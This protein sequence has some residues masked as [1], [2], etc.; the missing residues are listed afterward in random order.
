LTTRPGQKPLLL[1]LAIYGHVPQIPTRA[2]NGEVDTDAIEAFQ[3]HLSIKIVTSR[4]QPGDDTFLLHV[5][6][7]ANCP[8]ILF[9]ALL[10]LFPEHVTQVDLYGRLPLHVALW[11][12]CGRAMR[13]LVAAHSEAVTIVDPLTQMRPVEKALW[14][15]ARNGTVENVDSLYAMLQANPACI[16]HIGNNGMNQEE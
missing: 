14:N 4:L 10:E 15:V 5:A 2:K 16:M 13:A 12:H 7:A 3:S 1:K 8:P 9:E 6:L 11:S